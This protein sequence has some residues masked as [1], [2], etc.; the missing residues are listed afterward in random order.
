[1]SQNNGRNPV[2]SEEYATARDFEQIFNEDMTALYLL[3]FLLTGDRDKAE[4]CF[5][6]GIGES[7]KG[8][9]VFKEWARSWAR[10]TIV[11]G[12]IRLIAPR[13]NAS[14]A[15]RTP[16]ATR[17][18]DRVPFVLQKEVSAILELPQLERFVFVMSGL[19]CYSDH[20]CSILLGCTRR[21]YAVVR[22]RAARRLAGLLGLQPKDQPDSRPEKAKSEEIP[23]PA[24]ELLISRHFATSESNFS[25]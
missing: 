2:N 10:R 4:K 9:R 6:A 15:M 1:M 11:R 20:N 25:S 17:E 7:A 23:G 21:D 5:V 18:M 24:I 16:A 12:A 8:S 22:A 14:N 3:S 19:E 13:Q